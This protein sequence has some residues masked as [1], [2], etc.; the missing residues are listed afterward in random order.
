MIERLQKFLASAGL[1]S[2]RQIENW[3]RAG[4]ITVNGVPAQLG[5]RVSSADQIEIDGKPVQVSA[6]RQRRRVL[7]YYKP[8]GEMTT[9]HDPEG[10]PTVFDRLPTLREGRWIVVGR[11]D[12][13]TQGLL[14]ITTDGELAHRL[15]HPSSEIEREYAVRLLGEVTP[16]MVQRL[17]EGVPL[18]DGLGRFDAVRAVG[19]EGANHWYHVILH[20]GRNREVRRLW[21][22]QG[23]TV[24]RLI[25]VRY[26]PVT[27]RRGLH[28]GRWDEL[29]DSQIDELCA[30]AGYSF[31]KEPLKKAVAERRSTAPKRSGAVR[32]HQSTDKRGARNAALSGPRNPSLQEGRHDSVSA[33]SPVPRSSVRWGGPSS[34]SR[35]G[36]KAENRPF[37]RRPFSPGRAKSDR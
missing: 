1:G 27:L 2:R 4:R 13:N 6:H 9:R 28:P 22:S 32:L 33:A 35:R 3:L 19:G 11:L 36:A 18:E 14:L 29:N 37:P 8:V 12:L 25:R 21:E 30:A 16:D 15:M 26:G 34:Q 10:R 24:S 20:E 31:P 17:T 23:L 7:A 5:M